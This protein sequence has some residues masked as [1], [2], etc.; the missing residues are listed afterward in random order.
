[1]LQ[2]AHFCMFPFFTKINFRMIKL[3][4]KKVFQTVILSKAFAFG[5][6]VIL[7]PGR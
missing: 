7:Q 1:M 6:N 5:C 2:T 3:S 4:D